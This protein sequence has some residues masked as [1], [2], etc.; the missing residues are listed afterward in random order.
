MSETTS[1]S[2]CGA[3]YE[4]TY[5]KTIDGYAAFGCTLFQR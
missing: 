4:V 5:T 1:C 3:E 2:H